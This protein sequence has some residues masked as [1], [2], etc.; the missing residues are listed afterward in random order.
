VIKKI[1]QKEVIVLI[2]EGEVT[3]FGESINTPEEFILNL[4]ERTDNVYAIVAQE[5]GKMRQLAYII[6]FLRG[7]KHRMNRVCEKPFIK[8]DFTIIGQDDIQENRSKLIF[9]G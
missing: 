6:G 7:L 1:K 3:F 8:F 9:E 5:E 4:C 2:I